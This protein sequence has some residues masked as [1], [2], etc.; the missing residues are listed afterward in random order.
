MASESINDISEADQPVDYTELVAQDAFVGEYPYDSIMEGIKKQFSSYMSTDDRTNYV[1]KFYT[2]MHQ[3]FGLIKDEE[4]DHPQEKRDVLNNILDDFVSEIHKLFEDKL[5]I[6]IMD[7]D[8]EVYDQDNIEVSVRLLY[9]FFILNA[10]E[11][12]KT[13]IVND[14]VYQMKKADVDDYG[15]NKFAHNVLDQYNPL[16]MHLSIFEFIAFAKNPDVYELFHGGDVVGNFL[17]KFTPR[18]YANDEYR[19]NLI[20]DIIIEYAI[21]QKEG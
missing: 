5:S 3:S 13:A 11:T 20:N 17:Q 7:I 6:T 12:F 21:N 1:D 19:I 4:E 10:P 8:N 15:M 18:L 16:V 9:E 14:A 2:Q